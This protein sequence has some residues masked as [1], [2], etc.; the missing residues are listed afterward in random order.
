L[1]AF[2]II[3]RSATAIAIEIG[4]MVISHEIEAY[5]SVGVDPI[6]YIAVPRFIGVTVSLFLLTIYFSIFGLAGSF[7][8]ARVFNPMPAAVYFDHLLQVLT[9]HD[10]LI[11][12]I[13]SITFGMVISIIAIMSGFSV[14]RASTEIPV[15][16]LK[17]VGACFAWVIIVD[18]LLSVIYYM[19][20]A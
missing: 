12:I 6:E 3:A 13:K 18:I 14:E 17:S 11:S 20:L 19:V 9:P 16:G 5:I 10:I 2:I 8:V 15:A 4:N 1:A 7:L